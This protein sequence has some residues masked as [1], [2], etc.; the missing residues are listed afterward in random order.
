M[1]TKLSE[2]YQT[3]GVYTIQHTY[4][5]RIDGLLSYIDRMNMSL[6]TNSP[7]F[8]TVAQLH[9]NWIQMSKILFATTNHIYWEDHSFRTRLIGISIS[10]L[11]ADRDINVKCQCQIRAHLQSN[12]SS[13]FHDQNKKSKF[14]FI[15]IGMDLFNYI[16]TAPRNGKANRCRTGMFEYTSS[17]FSKYCE[18]YTI[19]QSSSVFR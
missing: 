1:C 19:L 9:L 16:K 8:F 10:H 7:I 2:E 17:N 5:H 12:D 13:R 11:V 18:L 4:I 15:D 14:V 3:I 6:A